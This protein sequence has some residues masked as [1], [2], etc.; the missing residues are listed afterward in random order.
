MYISLHVK[1][2]LFLSDF[3]ETWNFLAYLKKHSI[4]FHENPSSGSRAVPCFGRTRIDMTKLT[5]AFRNFAKAP[6][7]DTLQNNRNNCNVITARVIA[8]GS[9][10]TLSWCSDYRIRLPHK[11]TVRMSTAVNS[12]T[13]VLWV[14][15]LLSPVIG[16]F[17]PWTA[18][19]NFS[20][21]IVLAQVPRWLYRNPQHTTV[22]TVKCWIKNFCVMT[23]CIIIFR[24]NFHSRKTRH[25]ILVCIHSMAIYAT[26]FLLHI[27]PFKAYRLSDAPTV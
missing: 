26:S 27:K 15:I 21:E 25:Y 1:Y 7:I 22:K 4:K 16:R 11:T 17:Q 19:Q 18:R 9:L 24:A 12:R 8:D 6:K 3:N 2:L 23:P 10:M 13:V 5:A 14:M 20:P